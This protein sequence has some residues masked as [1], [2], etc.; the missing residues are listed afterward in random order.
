M[1][2]NIS[3][4]LP[5][6]SPPKAGDNSSAVGGL[7]SSEQKTSA[8]AAELS[9]EE[10][11]HIEKLKKADQE[12]KAH[13]AAHKNAGGQYAGSASFSYTVGPDG[14]RYA[15]SGE[16]SI[17]IAPIKDDPEATLAKL[18][19]V[20]AAALAPT[21]PSAQDRKVA[22]AAVAARNTARAELLDKKKTEEADGNVIT[23]SF[24][25]NDFGDTPSQSV[26]KAYASG[27]ELNQNNSNAGNNFNVSS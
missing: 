24:D 5:P 18:D 15:T 10:L 23:Q 22:A 17:D 25:V 11:A 19:V 6:L 16:V 14:K 3:T 20:I 4:Q 1:I 27:N 8:Q 7:S 2:S 26:N 21:K 13:E 12:V 9:K